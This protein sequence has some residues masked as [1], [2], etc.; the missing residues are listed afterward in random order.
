MGPNRI[1][2]ALLIRM[3]TPPARAAALRLAREGAHV[4]GCDLNPETSAETVEL[5]RAALDD[6]VVGQG[7]YAALGG[8]VRVLGHEERAARGRDGRDVDDGPAAGRDQVRPGGA[9]D[10]EHD[11]ELVADGE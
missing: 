5:V 3:S 2:D 4:V 1:A 7:E 6:E 11:V 8:A 9:R 10:E